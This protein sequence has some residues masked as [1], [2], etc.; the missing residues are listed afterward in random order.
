MFT[1]FR[2]IK[3]L[4]G[5]QK[6]IPLQIM[7]QLEDKDFPFENGKLIKSRIRW[8]ER[9]EELVTYMKM[10]NINYGH[11]PQHKNPKHPYASLGQW[12]ASQK[13]RRKGISPP[14][15]TDYEE[16]KMNSINFKWQTPKIGKGSGVDDESWLNQYFRLEEYKKKVGH[17][18]PSQ[19]DKDI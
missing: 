18:N 1:W 19:M 10:H 2:K 7:K 3:Y 17:A 4:L 9:F 11:V 15:W 16:R 5:K 8:E 13:L 14:V 12:C 6:E